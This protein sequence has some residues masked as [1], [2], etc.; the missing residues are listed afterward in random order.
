MPAGD[1]SSN[2]SLRWACT[3]QTSPL[4]PGGTLRVPAGT[5][6]RRALPLRL[7]SEEPPAAQRRTPGSSGLE[8]EGMSVTCAA[9]AAPRLGPACLW[10]SFHASLGRCPKY[11]MQRNHC[12]S[13]AFRGQDSEWEKVLTE[14]T[15]CP[16]QTMARGRGA[17][18]PAA[19]KGLETTCH[20]VTQASNAVPRKNT[21]QSR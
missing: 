6:Y 8:V 13:E 3:L 11:F 18:S 7:T 5:G 21:P 14:R 1:K 9:R 19:A 16:V 12:S 15:D 10:P 4:L 2:R 20:P 17:R